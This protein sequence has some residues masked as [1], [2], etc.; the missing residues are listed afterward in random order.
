MRRI[1]IGLKHRYGTAQTRTFAK[2]KKEKPA[3][4]SGYRVAEKTIL[5][6][7]AFVIYEQQLSVRQ[8]ARE[9]NST[10]NSVERKVQRSNKEVVKSKWQA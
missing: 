10:A 3:K 2:S 9:D 7:T 1:A 5:R 4:K 6:V 8:Q